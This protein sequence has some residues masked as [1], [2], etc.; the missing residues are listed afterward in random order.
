MQ[1]AAQS[2]QDVVIVGGGLVGATMACLLRALPLR[3][4]LV[5]Q[6]PFDSSTIP[7]VAA[8]PAFDPRVSALTASSIKQFR[9]L[10]V[11][12]AM[13]QR[14]VCEYHDMHVWEADGTGSIHFSAAAIGEPSL[15][16]IVENSV[17]LAAL[18]ESMANSPGLA[19]IAPFTITSLT[20]RQVDGETLLDLVSA[21][22][23][24]LTTRLLIAADGSNSRIRQ[25]AEFP[26][27]DWEYNHHALV[28]TVRTERPHEG[29]ALQ[30]F[31]DTGPLAFLPLALSAADGEQH[32]SSIVWSA[33]PSR[34]GELMAM[35]ENTFNRELTAAIE[36]RLGPVQ[37]SAHRF[38]F[39]LNQRHATSYVQ[40]NIVLVGD[41]AHTIHPLAGQGVN[42]GLLDVKVLAAE[43]IHGLAAGRALTDPILL[44]RYQRQRRGQNLGMM[45]LMEGFKHLFADQALPVRWLRN[46]GLRS[47]DNLAIVKNLLARRAMGLD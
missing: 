46:A 17:M 43:L 19:L 4:A 16:A 42:L 30:R 36:N 1:D 28:T 44:K 31:M 3:V 14:R 13:Q 15:G 21:D 26:T 41:A 47:V 22:G 33:I 9:E 12:E 24:T 18:Y 38:A 32:Y 10:G 2:I 8:Q 20:R 5:D 40:E 45:W 27:K 34:S 37:W 7:F 25:L 23:S 29:Q 35:D 11:W 39:P 6:K